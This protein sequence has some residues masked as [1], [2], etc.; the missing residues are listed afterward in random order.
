MQIN[1]QPTTSQFHAQ[2]FFE[3]TATDTVLAG[4]VGPFMAA[5]INRVE[6][7]SHREIRHCMSE[8]SWSDESPMGIV[9]TIL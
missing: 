7:K 5:R 2:R 6:P 4:A 3:K 1:S 9:S 8:R